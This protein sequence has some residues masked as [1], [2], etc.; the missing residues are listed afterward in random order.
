ME[1]IS[2]LFQ[3]CRA[4]FLY[5]VSFVAK[6]LSQLIT[7][8]AV[9]MRSIL[10]RQTWRTAAD[11][12]LRTRI[13]LII[14]TRR[15]TW[16]H[17]TGLCTKVWNKLH[18]PLKTT[19]APF[20]YISPL[21]WISNGRHCSRQL[22]PGL[23]PSVSILPSASGPRGWAALCTIQKIAVG[24]SWCDM[25]WVSLCLQTKGAV[26]T[27]RASGGKKKRRRKI[28]ALRRTKDE[29]KSRRWVHWWRGGQLQAWPEIKRSSLVENPRALYENYQEDEGML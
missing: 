8:P 21:N 20:T 7:L 26:E 29:R 22:L 25:N 28:K 1:I 14:H 3:P 23:C 13:R 11:R 5:F 19:L 18:F 24:V 10:I 27:T 2:L 17:P 12:Q 15:V 16:H 6:R 4:I 9:T